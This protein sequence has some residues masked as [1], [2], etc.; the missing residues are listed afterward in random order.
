M[1]EE[2]PTATTFENPVSDVSPMATSKPSDPT[3]A[4]PTGEAANAQI[5]S[6]NDFE[7]FGQTPLPEWRQQFKDIDDN[8]VKSALSALCTVLA[9]FLPDVKEMTMEPENDGLVDVVM[10]FVMFFFV[11]EITV[12]L[13]AIRAYYTSLFFWLD[14]A[15]TFSLIPEVPF[16][17][18]LA[19]ETSACTAA[20]AVGGG[21]DNTITRAGRAARAGARAGRLQGL[22]R[23]A[24]IFRILQLSKLMEKTGM[25]KVQPESL[26]EKKEKVDVVPEVLAAKISYSLSRIMIVVVIASIVCASLFIYVPAQYWQQTSLEGVLSSYKQSLQTHDTDCSNSTD[27][28][29]RSIAQIPRFELD[30]LSMWSGGYPHM[31][32]IDS[33]DGARLLYLA[34]DVDDDGSFDPWDSETLTGEVFVDEQDQ[35]DLL[36]DS[37]LVDVCGPGYIATYDG[38]YDSQQAATG[39]IKLTVTIV[40]ILVFA[41]FILSTEMNSF[42]SVPMQRLLKSQAL[43]EA[44]LTVFMES[45]DPI[46]TLESSCKKILNCEVVNIFFFDASKNEFWCTRTLKDESP[47]A[48]ELRMKFGEGTV[49]KCAKSAL[50]VVQEYD[51]PAE[52]DKKDP[53]LRSKVPK[54]GKREAFDW[55]ARSVMCYPLLFQVGK[56]T[57]CVGV[58]QAINKIPEARPATSLWDN[59]KTMVGLDESDE[60]SF[61]AFEL[62]M[63][64]MF[65]REVSQILKGFQMDAM[66]EN[67]FKDDSEEAAVMQSMM[68]EYATADVVMAAKEKKD[69]APDLKFMFDLYDVDKSGDLDLDELKML[70]SEM[71]KALTDEELQQA[72]NE[73]DADGG[74]T[75]CYPEFAEWWTSSNSLLKQHMHKVHAAPPSID[76]L[77][78]GLSLPE[79]SELRQWGFP[80][81]NYTKEQLCGMS[82][83]MM[84][85]PELDICQDFAVTPDTLM[86][87]ATQLLGDSY[88]SVPYHNYY[89]AFS[90]LQ[91]SYFL[92]TST[93]ICASFNS[94]E[95]FAMLIA[96]MGHDAGHDGVNTAFHVD[97]KSELAHLYNDKSPLENMHARETFAAMQKPGCDVMGSMEKPDFKTARKLIVDAIVGTDMAFHKLHVDELSAKHSIDMEEKSE[98]DMLMAC[99]VHLVD[100]GAMSYSWDEAPRW[101]R[102]VMTEFQAQV[103]QEKSE[104]MA[105][106]GFMDIMGDEVADAD[107][108][109]KFAA[110]Q[111]GFVGFV[112][113]P[114]FALFPPHM[115]E[116]QGAFDQLKANK[117]TWEAIKAGTKE[118]PPGLEEDDEKMRWSVNVGMGALG[119]SKTG[120]GSCQPV[121]KLGSSGAGGLC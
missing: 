98:R 11:C 117:E 93:E 90:V 62:D 2:D 48:E 30:D 47:Y 121:L 45:A 65:G 92:C 99:L 15:A 37:E 16:L 75:V 42:L 107:V 85:D 55:S 25:R 68:S 59:F 105:V 76:R 104:G 29:K 35:K 57:E 78:T 111:I 97:S 41:G 112:L 89:H 14:V 91:G 36:R 64:A 49:G 54:R 43:S 5:S 40:A 102:M 69:K 80:C 53:S 109:G 12:Q 86:K 101:S 120:T 81:L 6:L 21:I 8:T 70:A 51:S 20:L 52:V 67:V 110:S 60:Q 63:L 50:P 56:I 13:C 72:I 100:V 58:M 4:P 87:F 24:R 115:P 61:E 88:N 19:S 116:L 3:S 32:G 17:A 66:Y 83:M 71:G 74:G 31:D 82:L 77:L 34:L 33:G 22:I 113:M 103:N 79:L 94:L 27:V 18:G 106:S 118:L 23:V 108:K 84:T 119:P 10:T 28:C 9:L 39:R 95:K 1:A 46:P 44:L 114:F 96:G 7:M 26:E 38:K 73:M